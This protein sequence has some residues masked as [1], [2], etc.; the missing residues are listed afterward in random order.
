MRARHSAVK[1]RQLA[2]RAL[3]TVTLSFALLAAWDVG[4]RLSG[5]REIQLPSPSCIVQVGLLQLPLIADHIIL[6]S[7][8]RRSRTVDSVDKRAN[9]PYL[10][11]LAARYRTCGFAHRAG[12]FTCVYPL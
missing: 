11:R 10:G 12:Q 2:H 3:P 1:D 5:L 9:S 4:A 6:I 7:S 8:S